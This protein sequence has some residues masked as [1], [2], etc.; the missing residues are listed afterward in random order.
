MASVITLY[1]RKIK[2]EERKHSVSLY[3]NWINENCKKPCR[4]KE[5]RNLG[6]GK[7][8]LVLVKNELVVQGHRGGIQ[9]EVYSV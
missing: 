4:I 9:F 1:K 8:L 2:I 3:I 7:F 6:D 5:E